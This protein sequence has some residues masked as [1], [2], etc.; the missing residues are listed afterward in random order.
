MFIAPDYSRQLDQIVKALNRGVMPTWLV[1]VISV[2]L[3][4]VLGPIC[5][6]IFT[7][8][9]NKQRMRRVIYP[10]LADMYSKA[11]HFYPLKTN[12]DPTGDQ[13]WR[14][15]R[16]KS[17]LRFAGEKYAKDNRAVY[18]QLPEYPHLDC[19][20]S[21]LRSAVGDEVDFDKLDFDI[22]CGL[23][24]EI[25]EDCVRLGQLPTKYIKKYVGKEDASKLLDGSKRKIT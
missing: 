3:G 16:L 18:L 9:V 20:Y 15:A 14:L 2:V 19:I 21:A 23:A 10:D 1:A 8:H 24:V 13:D 4:S 12:L 6:H 22:N 17:F 7:E 25:I 5:H 11:H